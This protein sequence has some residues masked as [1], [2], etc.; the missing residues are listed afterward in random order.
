[1]IHIFSNQKSQI[2]VIFGGPC[3][4]RCWHILWTFGLFYSLLVY[5]M[6]NRYILWLFGIFFTRFGMLRQEKSGNPAQS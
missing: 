2:W 4:G 3:I 6:D 5:F 1:M